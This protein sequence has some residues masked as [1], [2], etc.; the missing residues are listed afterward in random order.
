M[1]SLRGAAPERRATLKAPFGKTIALL[2][3]RVWL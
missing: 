1:M 2:R 3:L